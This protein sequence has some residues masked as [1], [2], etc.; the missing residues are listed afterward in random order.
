M[1]GLVHQHLVAGGERVD[2]RRFPSARARGR[3]DD[4]RAVG[5]EDGLDAVEHAVAE[6]LEF[7]PAMVENRH[8]HGAQDAVGHRRRAGDLQKMASG[9]ALRLV[10]HGTLSLGLAGTVGG[11]A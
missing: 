2:E 11:T 8:V 4:D 6:L 3:V 5:L 7:R 1:A 10:G 9:A